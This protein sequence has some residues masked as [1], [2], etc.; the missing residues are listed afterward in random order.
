M[1]FDFLYSTSHH[2]FSSQ[3]DFGGEVERVLNMADGVLLVVDSV[4]GP[5]PQTRFVLDKALRKGLKALV[6]VNK[7]DR[8]AA[9]PEYVVDKVFDLM[10]E[11]NADDEQC[12]FKVVYAS[13]LLGKAGTE[14]DTLSNDMAPLFDAVIGAIDPPKFSSVK[15]DSLQCMVSNIDYDAFKGKMGV[16]RIS[17][18]TV[19]KNQ[20]VALVHPGKPKK[21]GRIVSKCWRPTSRRFS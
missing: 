13:G 8:P 6:V 10:V 3:T 9:R 1:S 17:E 18:G 4:E 21:T 11:L 15:T 19:R 16:S 7:I 20:A 12:D 5:K 14:P 2:S